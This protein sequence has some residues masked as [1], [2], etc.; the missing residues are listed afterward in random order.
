MFKIML[1]IQ[2]LSSRW[3]PWWLSRLQPFLEEHQSQQPVNEL[4]LFTVHGYHMVVKVTTF[5]KFLLECSMDCDDTMSICWHL[6]D[7]HARV[8]LLIIR[9]AMFMVVQVTASLFPEHLSQYPFN[10]NWLFKMH[11]KV[12][13][14]TVTNGII[15]VLVHFYTKYG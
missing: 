14:R 7:I 15:S 1:V 5:L 4:W 2:L 6:T 12:L 10:R 9:M 3:Q 8:W 13:N 11:V